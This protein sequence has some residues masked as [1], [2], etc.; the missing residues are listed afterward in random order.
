MR[1]HVPMDIDTA[2]ARL[3]QK[4]DNLAHD[5]ADL[6]RLRGTVESHGRA[7]TQLSDLVAA[8]AAD[9]P[10][11]WADG[12]PDG[13]ETPP[14]PEW[15]RVED[16]AQ[17]IAWLNGL[18]VWVPRVWALY[19]GSRLTPCWPW[20]PAIVAELLVNQHLWLKA[21]TSGPA[22]EPLAAWHDRWR[23][24]AAVRVTRSLSGCERGA[25]CH[26]NPAGHHFTYDLD[27]LEDLA[28]WWATEDRHDVDAAPGLTRERNHPRYSSDARP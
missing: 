15:L 2:V 18:T 19:P 23:P 28:V 7:L 3:A 22:P 8:H 13:E 6:A 21:S 20:H 12:D 11:G 10:A 24:A 17:A 27:H 1:R 26:V 9:R 16:P 14:P 4:V 25:G 5:L